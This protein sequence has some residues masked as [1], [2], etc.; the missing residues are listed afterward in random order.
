MFGLAWSVLAGGCYRGAARPLDPAAI[1]RDPAW[2]AVTT[3]PALRQH[4]AEDCGHTVAAMVLTAWGTP[5]TPDEV[6]RT[7]G[8][9]ATKALPAGRLRTY[10]LARGLRVFLLEGALPDL[11]HELRAGRPV[12]VGVRR[13]FGGKLYAHYQV[14]VGVDPGGRRLAVLDPADGLLEIPFDGFLAEWAPTRHLMLVAF[15]PTAEGT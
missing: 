4:G 6:V 9:P 12:V 2:I 5:T 7:I 1:T 11:E 13:T 3:V 10:L 8:G 15:A 14:V